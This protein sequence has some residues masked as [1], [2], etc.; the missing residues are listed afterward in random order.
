MTYQLLFLFGAGFFGGVLN[1]IAGGGSFITFPA[2]LFVGVPPISANATNTFASCAGYLSGAYA[3]RKDLALHRASLPRLATIS[4]VGGSTGA[5]LLLQTPEAVFRQAI[6]WLLLFATLLF[7][8]GG[9]LN[10]ALKAY[11]AIHR[12]ASL[13]GGL[14]LLLLLLGVSV[15]GGFFNAGLGI[16]ILSYLAL[17]GHTDINAMNG[18]KLLISSVISLIAILMFIMD[19]A[20]A[21]YEG[22]L[23]MLGTLAGGYV[24]AHLSRRLPQRHI[25]Y[26]V[27]LVGGGMSLYFFFRTY[28]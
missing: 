9:R 21:W 2:L 10:G 19:G 28:Y 7:I 11:A 20:I 5:L 1:S 17:A 16:I 22:V 8:F 15:Y 25:R 6:P 3:F 13:V 18:L 24:A 4:L 27:I 14:L 12:H 26:V 23:V